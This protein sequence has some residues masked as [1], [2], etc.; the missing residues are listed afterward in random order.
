MA[1]AG[2]MPAHAAAALASGRTGVSVT[3]KT[4]TKTTTKTVG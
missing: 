1:L 3:A 2:F 4:T